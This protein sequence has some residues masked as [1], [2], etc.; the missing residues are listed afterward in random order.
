MEYENGLLRF[1]DSG[2]YVLYYHRR[3]DYMNYEEIF[4]RVSG[5]IER[6]LT[7]LKN[8][9]LLC[10]DWAVSADRCEAWRERYR[11]SE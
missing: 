2:M 6:N 9:S 1:S 5:A 7:K 11:R 3:F 10:S 8:S 4:T